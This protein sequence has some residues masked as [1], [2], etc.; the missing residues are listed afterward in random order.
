MI[1]ALDPHESLD[2]KEPLAQE[3]GQVVQ[4]FC[5][6]VESHRFPEPND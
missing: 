2:T 1:G 4:P 3:T 5:E 6:L